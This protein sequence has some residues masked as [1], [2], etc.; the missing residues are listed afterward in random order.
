MNW[1]DPDSWAWICVT[2]LVMLAVATLRLWAGYNSVELD[3]DMLTAGT[4]SGVYFTQAVLK[5]I[6]RNKQAAKTD[7]PPDADVHR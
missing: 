6:I 7:P 2:G 3:K 4:V 5:K 1:N